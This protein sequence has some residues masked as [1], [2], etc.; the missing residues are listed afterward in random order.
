MSGDSEEKRLTAAFAAMGAQPRQAETMAKQTL[1]R[2]RQL[3][4]ERGISEVEALDYLLRMIAAG[5]AGEAIEPPDRKK[6]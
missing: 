5:R 6:T 4:A 3:S 1:K 2:A